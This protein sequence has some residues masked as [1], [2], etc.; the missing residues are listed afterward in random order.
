MLRSQR[1]ILKFFR[2]IFSWKTSPALSTDV[3]GNN[4]QQDNKSLRSTRDFCCY[5]CVREIKCL[6]PGT[7]CHVLCLRQI[8]FLKFYHLKL[9]AHY[10]QGCIRMV[11]IQYSLW[12][13]H[14]A[15]KNDL[16]QYW[17]HD[18]FIYPVKHSSKCLQLAK[19]VLWTYPDKRQII[20]AIK[21][22]VSHER[23]Q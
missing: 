1:Y 13:C 14:T 16:S 17:W 3:F 12:I 22:K 7:W 2:A 5:S 21:Y 18:N 15:S 9:P 23:T 4:Q 11:Q 8:I 6:L 10:N 20:A 19:P